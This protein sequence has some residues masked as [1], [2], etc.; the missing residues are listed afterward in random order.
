M[1]EVKDELM[2]L[3]KPKSARSGIYGGYENYDNYE[4]HDGYNQDSNVVIVKDEDRR[5]D[6]DGLRDILPIL[7]LTLL[8]NTNRNNVVA[9]I[10]IERPRSSISSLLPFL[11][12]NTI[13]G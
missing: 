3:M 6:R 1:D 9:P 4:N 7:L 2:Q 12:Q 10:E 11:G 5:R 13:L 8:G